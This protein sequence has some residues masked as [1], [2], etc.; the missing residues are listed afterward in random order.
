[1]Q[2]DTYI[3]SV[4]PMGRRRR[5]RDTMLTLLMWGIYIYLWIPLITLGAWLV[6]FERF[7]EVVV[8]YGG[9]EM[10]LDMLDWYAMVIVGIAT[11][12][13]SW[14][15]INYR[16]FRNKERRRGATVV[17]SRQ[18]SEFYGIPPAE[19]DHARLS[20]RILIDLDE[21]GFI[22]NI[23]HYGYVE[24]GKSRNSVDVKEVQ[25]L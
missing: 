10:V 11:I 2:N 1:M 6:G 5:T 12:I 8:L 9:Y 17:S 23:T 16:R 3:V 24:S 22:T 7:Y 13:V 21:L 18:I 4:K 14:S 25:S 20:K 19:V 15:G